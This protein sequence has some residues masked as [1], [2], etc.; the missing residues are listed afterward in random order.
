MRELYRAVWV[1]AY[2]ELLRFLQ[3]RSRILFS[4]AVP[5]LNLV[6]FGV[7]LNHLIGSLAPGV[8]FVKFI[9][10]AMITLS[11]MVTSL[12]SGPSLL[13]D[14]ETGYLKEMLVS[15]LSRVGIVLGKT[16]GFGAVAIG[17][18]L[19]MLVVAPLV[20]FPLSVLLVLNLVLLL[21]LV[22]LAMSALS[23][24][25]ALRSQS[26]ESNQVVMQF[27]TIP[28]LFLS[29]VFFPVSSVPQWLAVITKLNP[30]TY[31]VDA[32][33]QLFVHGAGQRGITG[34]DLGITVFGHV[35]TVWQDMLVVAVVGLLLL[36]Y[37]LW[38]FNR[39]E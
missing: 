37:A 24:A 32:V 10:P 26:L 39:E 15:P 31:A 16:A 5:L 4:I 14:R 1:V 12:N 35:M 7:G 30:V 27:L 33:R 38:S 11:V 22:S 19:M 2:R 34:G 3:E 23:I 8:N 9:F 17:Q 29:G 18:G 21:V 36:Q 25:I 28:L 6:I 13:L 20:G